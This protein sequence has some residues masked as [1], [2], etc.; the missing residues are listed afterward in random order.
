MLVEFGGGL[1][2][3]LFLEKRGMTLV[4]F[5][6]NIKVFSKVGKCAMTAYTIEERSF[7]IAANL[8]NYCSPKYFKG[9]IV[10]VNYV[11]QPLHT[12]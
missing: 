12:Y 7:K 10:T 8:V 9:Y 2:S 11:G 6:L 5:F 4:I 3:S 1:L